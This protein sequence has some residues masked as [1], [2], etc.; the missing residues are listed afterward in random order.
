MI[1]VTAG[2]ASKPVVKDPIPATESL[3]EAAAHTSKKPMHSKLISQQDEEE[4]AEAEAGDNRGEG[5]G[6][7][8]SYMDPCKHGNCPCR[9]RS[10]GNCCF[11]QDRGK[12]HMKRN[13][14]EID[15]VD[16][17]P[18]RGWLDDKGSYDYKR[19]S[20]LCFRAQGQCKSAMEIVEAGEEGS[21]EPC[22][23]ETFADVE[24]KLCEGFSDTCGW[25]KILVQGFHLSD[26]EKNGPGGY[27]EWIREKWTMSGFSHYLAQHILSQRDTDKWKSKW[28]KKTI[29]E[30]AYFEL[31]CKMC[32]FHARKCKNDN[33]SESN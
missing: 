13:L 31:H 6:M 5:E 10:S 18:E 22:G 1:Q 27:C 15:G 8:T 3:V 28:D 2:G 11:S 7:M 21:A 33:Q 12:H 23:K 17:F 19:S 30:D 16:P 29:S 4:E 14:D 25:C 9:K 24:K 20:R 32:T 26:C